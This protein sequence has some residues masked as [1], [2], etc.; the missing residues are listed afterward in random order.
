[1]ESVATKS[2]LSIPLWGKHGS[3]NPEKEADSEQSRELPSLPMAT[4]T[5]AKNPMAEGKEYSN[6]SASEG[7][8]TRWLGDR[9]VEESLPGGLTETDIMGLK[10]WQHSLPS[11]GSKERS[12][13]WP[14]QLLEAFRELSPF[15]SHQSQE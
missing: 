5:N 8:S 1:M 3:Q 15:F 11:G 7:N 10:Y 4:L 13:S 12:L 9:A 6:F 2:L 14:Y